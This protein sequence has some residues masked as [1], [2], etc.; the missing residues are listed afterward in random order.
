MLIPL[1]LI[2]TLAAV[3]AVFVPSA[4]AAKTACNSP[5]TTPAPNSKV[6][7][8]LEVN[9]TCILVGVTVNGGIVIDASGRLGFQGGGVNGGITNNGGELDLNAVL[10]AGTPTD[11]TSKIAGGIVLN[12]TFDQD[13][14][15]STITGGIKMT[16]PGAFPAVCGNDITGGVSVTNYNSGQALIGDPDVI[17]EGGALDCPG[18]TIH[19]PVTITN[20]FTPLFP[21]SAAVE[22]EGNTIYG[23]VTADASQVE[24]AGNTITGPVN[25]VNGAV[26]ILSAPPDLLPNNLCS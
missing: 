18:N 15:N 23:P 7:G 4:S 2:G 22:V 26:Q 24:I 5:G 20:A 19:G 10:F 3:V 17:A 11:T 8:G 12:S 13:I 9:G 6:N 1:A 16:N 25:C 21:T 14:W